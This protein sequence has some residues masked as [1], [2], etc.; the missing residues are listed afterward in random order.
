V[1][2]TV[3]LRANLAE[4]RAG[5]L[6]TRLSALPFR[7][8]YQEEQHGSVLVVVIDCTPAQE[9]IVRNILNEIGAP[10]ADET[11]QDQE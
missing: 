8:N 6:Q 9:N 11:E 7:V 5:D 10:T 2:A 1:K 4:S 3:H